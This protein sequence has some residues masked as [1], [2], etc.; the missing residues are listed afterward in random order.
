M[1]RLNYY[2]TNKYVDENT[3]QIFNTIKIHENEF[4]NIYKI[5][6][7]YLKKNDVH[8]ISD[9]CIDTD[10]AKDDLRRYFTKRKMGILSNII[11]YDRLLKRKIRILGIN[12]NE[13]I[14]KYVTITF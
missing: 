10:K 8:N 4:K 11:G 12:F 13:F 9:I 2:F 6:S 3:K 5:L 1:N 7:K 14:Q